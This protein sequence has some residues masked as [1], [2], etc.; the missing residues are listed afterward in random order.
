MSYNYYFKDNNLYFS[1]YLKILIPA[2]S[3]N[4]FRC[5]HEKI[6]KVSASTNSRHIFSNFQ[7]KNRYVVSFGGITGQNSN[8][9]YESANWN[10]NKTCE[11]CSQTIKTDK[12][13]KYLPNNDI[14]FFN[15]FKNPKHNIFNNN[16]FLSFFS[17][18]LIQREWKV[19]FEWFFSNDQT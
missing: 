1:M 15:R 8:K 7:E 12:N 16:R 9:Q 3:G 14:K 13:W 6:L 17:K 10:K 2:N 4:V 18:E 11:N 19:N 5:F